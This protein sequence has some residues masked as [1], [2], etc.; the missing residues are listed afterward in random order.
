[1]G[2]AKERRGCLCVE[3]SVLVGERAEQRQQD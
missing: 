2:P 3:R 1:M